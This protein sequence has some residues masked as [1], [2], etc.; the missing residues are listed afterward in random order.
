MYNSILKIMTV[1]ALTTLG[2]PYID[3]QKCYT[4]ESVYSRDALADFPKN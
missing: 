3:F 2:M 4:T 1:A